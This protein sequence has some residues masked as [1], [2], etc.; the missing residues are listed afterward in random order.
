[1]D[2][3]TRASGSPSQLDL[4]EC[5]K[6]IIG[7]MKRLPVLKDWDEAKRRGEVTS[8]ADLVRFFDDACM[9]S[10]LLTIRAFDEFYR[11]RKE[12]PKGET[13]LKKAQKDDLN[14]EQYGFVHDE[15]VL[16][17]DRRKQLNKELAHFTHRRATQRLR[18]VM[19]ED[20]FSVLGPCIQFLD[21]VLSSGLLDDHQEIAK[22]AQAVRDD[23]QKTIHD[24]SWGVAAWT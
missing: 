19:R 15:P 13:H 3:N 1:M 24:P 22:T 16:A 18:T 14:A 4:A 6:F 21:H 23:M 7:E 10:M 8:R 9:D 2:K 17:G 12:Q 11:L 20:V 5:L